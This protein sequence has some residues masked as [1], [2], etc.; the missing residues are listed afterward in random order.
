MRAK[1]TSVFNCN[2]NRKFRYRSDINIKKLFFEAMYLF[3]GAFA[4]FMDLF[5]LPVFGMLMV[6]AG[7]SKIC[8]TSHEKTSQWVC[9]C[10]QRYTT[11]LGKGQLWLSTRG[12]SVYVEMVQQTNK[13]LL[14]VCRNSTI[15]L[16]YE[17]VSIFI[18]ERETDRVDG[19]RSEL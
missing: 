19:E 8:W 16:K 6:D 7:V 11:I 13:N 14:C 9:M 4:A 15:D 12:I 2:G 5:G 18:H 1:G 17:S 10:M 3:I